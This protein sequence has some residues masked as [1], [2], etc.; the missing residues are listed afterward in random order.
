MHKKQSNS[1]THAGAS[2]MTTGLINKATALV[3]AMD[4]MGP[5][6]TKLQTKYSITYPPTPRLREH[7]GAKRRE[8]HVQLYV[9]NDIRTSI[10]GNGHVQAHAMMST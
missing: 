2:D 9:R 8:C 4:G 1:P 10:V 6:S 7:T 3:M 5:D